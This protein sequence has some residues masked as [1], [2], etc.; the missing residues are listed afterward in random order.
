MSIVLG[1]YIFTLSIFQLINS[2]TFKLQARSIHIRLANE[3]ISVRQ[4]RRTVC[5]SL[6][7]N[8][9]VTDLQR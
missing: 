2:R 8:V 5:Q 4:Y 3:I 7:L 6:S 1:F 9:I